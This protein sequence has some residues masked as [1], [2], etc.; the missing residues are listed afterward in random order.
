MPSNQGRTNTTLDPHSLG[1]HRRS[2][3]IAGKACNVVIHF[4]ALQLPPAGT[5]LA[6]GDQCLPAGEGGGGGPQCRILALRSECRDMV[7]EE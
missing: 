4:H 3:L 6:P 1:P 2:P 7:E 5:Y